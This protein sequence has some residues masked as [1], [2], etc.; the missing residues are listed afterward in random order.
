MAS[1]RAALLALLA[2]LSTALAAAPVAAAAGAPVAAPGMPILQDAGTTRCTLGYAA[3]TSAGERLAVTAGHCGKTGDPV[4]DRG[5]RIIGRYIA[6]QPD[7][8]D[9][10]TYG[11][12]LI[13]VRPDVALSAWLTPTFAI[14][15]QAQAAVGD[16]VCLFGTTSGMKCAAVA[17][18]TRD[19]GTLTGS[20]SAGGDSGGPIVRMRDHALVGILI[21]HDPDTDTT[22]FE[23]VV[24]IVT[25]AAAAGAVGTGFG[26]VIDMPSPATTS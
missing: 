18:I 23:P 26:P 11:Y 19:A 22:Q 8:L 17:T 4:F 1:G 5:R 24:T 9:T 7:D 16:D 3:R 21:G 6:V 13:Q 10:A 2:A 20:L 15:G 25:A 14:R 12:S